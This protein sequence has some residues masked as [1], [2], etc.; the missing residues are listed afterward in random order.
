MIK[1]SPVLEDEFPF[2]PSSA[3]QEKAGQDHPAM[4]F[5]TLSMSTQGFLSLRLNK[6]NSSSL[7]SQID[8]AI[9]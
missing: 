1:N 9:P 8:F 5:N 4:S 3:E 6:P 2:A 7:S